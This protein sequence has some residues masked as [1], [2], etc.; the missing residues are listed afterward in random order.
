MLAAEQAEHNI[1]LANALCNPPSSSMPSSGSNE[2]PTTELN[3][4]RTET[5]TE[6]LT[7]CSYG[8]NA[9]PISWFHNIYPMWNDQFVS[10]TR[11]E[12]TE[13]L[14]LRPQPKVHRL[15][16]RKFLRNLNTILNAHLCWYDEQL[17]R[18]TERCIQ[19]G[20][21]SRF[22]DSCLC[23]YRSETSDS[24]TTFYSIN[25]DIPTN[26]NTDIPTNLN[27]D[28]TVEEHNRPETYPIS[29][30][31]DE[32]GEV[33]TYVCCDCRERI[34]NECDTINMMRCMNCLCKLWRAEREHD[35]A[36]AT[37]HEIRVH[38]VTVIQRAWAR[39]PWARYRWKPP[40][41]ADRPLPDP[42]WNGCIGCYRD[43]TMHD[44][45]HDYRPGYCSYGK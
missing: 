23:Q 32:W 7:R 11:A 26:I 19:C 3:T 39:N 22:S 9:P 36:V 41:S 4:S 24:E 12:T 27:A 40:V 29:P 15:V 10:T 20:T 34:W 33:A 45:T 30:A 44:P 1:G 5:N 21:Y 42:P 16:K 43:R 31:Y 6:D 25:T 18:S 17:G 13:D 2:Q 28:N 38:A 14:P 35:Q 37:A 8:T